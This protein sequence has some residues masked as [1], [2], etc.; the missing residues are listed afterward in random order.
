MGLAK[1]NLPKGKYS[2]NDFLDES[3]IDIYNHFEEVRAEE[4][5]YP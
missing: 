1:G 4:D 3:F 5:L 2:V